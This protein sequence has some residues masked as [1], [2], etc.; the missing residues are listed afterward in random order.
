MPFLAI[1]AIAPA[2]IASGKGRN[3]FVWWVYGFLLIVIALPHSLL[4]SDQD[5]VKYSKK[6]AKKHY[7]KKCSY[8]GES[9]EKRE[10]TCPYCG[11]NPDDII[12]K[13]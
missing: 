1:L 2:M 11:N 9:I 5:S 4:I 7:T 12:K 6:R 10:A 3:F 13:K 8:C